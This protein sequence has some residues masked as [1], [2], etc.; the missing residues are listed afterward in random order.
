MQRTL[1]QTNKQYQDITNKQTLTNKLQLVQT[2]KQI[3]PS[4]D[5]ERLSPA[6]TNIFGNKHTYIPC[7]QTNKAN[8]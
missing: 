1:I 8:I 2:N 6:V 4:I 5:A 3:Y 7:Y